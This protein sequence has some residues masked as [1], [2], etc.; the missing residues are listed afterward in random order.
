MVTPSGARR[1]AAAWATILEAVVLA[2]YG[3]AVLIAGFALIGNAL[4]VDAARSGQAVVAVAGLA[5]ALLLLIFAIALLRG[6]PWA[7]PATIVLQLAVLL[8]GLLLLILGPERWL[9]AAAL[10]LSATVLGLLLARP[11]RT[12][13]PG[14]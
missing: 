14:A 11:A 7:R 3:A 13:A 10:L 1:P 8:G 9:G 12:A 5:S 2:L 4:F 6:A